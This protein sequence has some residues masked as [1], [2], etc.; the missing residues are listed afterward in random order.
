MMRKIKE[1]Y[2]K[3]IDKHIFEKLLIPATPK[4][5]GR[6]MSQKIREGNFIR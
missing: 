5:E 3:Y 6:H 2:G 1:F 4:I